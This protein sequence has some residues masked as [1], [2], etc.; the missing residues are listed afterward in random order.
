[1]KI[2]IDTQHDRMEDI[3]KVIH[4]LSSILNQKGSEI[5]ISEAPIDTSNL[6]SMFGNTPETKENLSPVEVPSLA[7]LN[8]L[9][10]SSSG[11]NSANKI[12]EPR[13]KV[14]LY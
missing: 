9:G 14:E 3:E 8:V 12:P 4:L 2:T 10:K 7:S 1:M 5:K 11:P 13:P 6:M